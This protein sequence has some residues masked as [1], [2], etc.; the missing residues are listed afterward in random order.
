MRRV[1]RRPQSVTSNGADPGGAA[2]DPVT[3]GGDACVAVPDRRVPETATYELA[4]RRR[5]AITLIGAPTLIAR[6]RVEGPAGAAQLAGRL[7][8]VGPQ[9]GRTLIARGFYRPRPGRNVWQLHPGA[10]RFRPGHAVQ[11][12]LLGS[13]APFGRPSNSA[14][15][16]EIQRLELRLPVRERPDCRAVL[17][18]L[19]PIRPRGQRLAPGVGAAL[20][21]ARAQGCPGG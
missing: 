7:W 2:V 18:P 20:R 19:P 3:G 4:A 6:L 12:E 13:D 14:F 1:F 15:A 16:V 8:D 9:G 21:A 10:W 5:R 17:R 11:L